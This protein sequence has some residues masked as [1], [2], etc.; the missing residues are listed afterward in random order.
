MSKSQRDSINDIKS[1]LDSSSN[2]QFLNR[3]KKR[4]P[5]ISSEI[6]DMQS[7]LNETRCSICLG[8]EK[9]VPNCYRCI[10]CSA[11]FH[12]ECYN[13][14]KFDETKEEILPNTENINNFECYRCKE[15]KKLETNIKC[16]A[17]KAH[18]G[19][20]KK[21]EEEKYLHHYCYVFF[22]DGF[23]VLKG[24]IC[25]SCAHKKIPVLKCQERNCKE[26]YHIQCAIDKK[27]IFWLPYMREQEKIKEETFNNQ[28]PFFCAEHNKP[29]MDNFAEFSQTL[30]ISKN[31]QHENN[32]SQ[33]EKQNNNIINEIS[34]NNII[35]LSPKKVT[36]INK[37]NEKSEINKK[38]DENSNEKKGIINTVININYP[39]EIPKQDSD[40]INKSNSKNNII[41]KV[42]IDTKKNNT[43]N[44]NLNL[45]LKKNSENFSSSPQINLGRSSSKALSNNNDI[46]N[47]TI[48]KT[49]DDLGIDIDINVEEKEDDDDEEY[50]PPEISHDKVDLF[51]NFRK[52]NDKFMIPGSFYKFHL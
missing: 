44:T 50:D 31:D 9:I 38:E 16:Y 5:N 30:L 3:K 7:S 14:F 43:N 15:E 23:D 19:I 12:I 10:T 37:T 27:I 4:D 29:L 20:I 46:I 24:G 40:K 2:K 6:I 17:C 34:N 28:I 22:K 1:D 42:E 32:I 33:N 21:F 39:K 36:E 51:E 49:Q 8:E 18:S 47:R 41:P 45:N 48:S 35:H 25:K 26:K 13:L 11:V 52:K